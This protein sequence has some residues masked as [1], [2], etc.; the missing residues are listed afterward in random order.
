LWNH[1]SKQMEPSQI[2]GRVEAIGGT[3]LAAPGKGEQAGGGKRNA[4]KGMKERQSG[5]L[6][7]GDRQCHLKSG[8][9]YR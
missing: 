1:L 3:P 2:Q 8:I 7:E 6:G 9:T 4:R 5:R